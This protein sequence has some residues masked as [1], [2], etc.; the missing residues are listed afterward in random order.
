[1]TH[2]LS[3]D[4]FHHPLEEITHLEKYLVNREYMN[5]RWHNPAASHVIGARK[6][7]EAMRRLE[8]LDALLPTVGPYL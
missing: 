7:D 8:G 2:R 4:Q 5:N 1:M 3:P 6:R